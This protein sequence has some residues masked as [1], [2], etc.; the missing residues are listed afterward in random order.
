MFGKICSDERNKHVRD[1]ARDE[2]EIDGHRGG[3]GGEGSEGE[4]RGSS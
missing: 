3:V 2:G 4:T 1:N